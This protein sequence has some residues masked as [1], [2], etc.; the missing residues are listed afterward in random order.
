MKG[1]EMVEF[2][3]WDRVRHTYSN[4]FGREVVRD[5]N[6]IHIS[7]GMI[8]YVTELGNNFTASSEYLTL[9]SKRTRKKVKPSKREKE[10]RAKLREIES[11][12]RPLAGDSV[13]FYSDDWYERGF[14]RGQINL[15]KDLLEIITEGK[16]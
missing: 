14:E 11:W 4:S 10:L 12:I 5:G 8:T 15:A 2:E 9:I 7:N 6:I 1:T 13:D 16:R 3:A